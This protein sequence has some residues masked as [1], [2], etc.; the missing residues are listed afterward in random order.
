MKKDL[1]KY[2]FPTTLLFLVLVMFVPQDSFAERKYS[3]NSYKKRKVVKQYKRYPKRGSYV[4][5]LPRKS[6]AMKHKTSNYHYKRG[7]YYK[8]DNNRYRVSRAPHGMRIKVLPRNTYS[9]LLHG[10][11]Y[12]Y[13]YGTYYKSYQGG[14]EV[15]EPP[16]GA[17]IDALPRGYEEVV[18]SGITYY[19]LDDN[20]YKAFVNSKGKV[21]YEL[22]KI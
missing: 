6:I 1:F 17:V 19:H 14:Y 13:Q 22:V 4:K 9:F 21:A 11:N 8:P 12:Y 3:K 5:K 20:Y 15:V 10:I 18:L 7:I 16:I 2:F